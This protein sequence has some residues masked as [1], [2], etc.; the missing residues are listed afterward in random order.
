MDGRRFKPR[1]RWSSPAVDPH[2]RRRHHPILSHPRPAM[3]TAPNYPVR[4]PAHRPA[5]QTLS[6]TRFKKPNVMKKTWCVLLM[7]MLFALG[8][9]AAPALQTLVSSGLS[10]PYGVTV[11]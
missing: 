4:R 3:N 6:L 7:S 8:A 10:E 1:G 5:A 2:Q 9:V 11:D